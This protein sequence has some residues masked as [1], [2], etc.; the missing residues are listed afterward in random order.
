MGC[1]L[2]TP[3]V[4]YERQLQVLWNLRYAWKSLEN[5]IP[6]WYLILLFSRPV[7]IVFTFL[8]GFWNL[9]IGLVIVEIDSF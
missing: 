7:E 2:F 1:A 4:V 9:L 5:N 6:N 3:N 8:T